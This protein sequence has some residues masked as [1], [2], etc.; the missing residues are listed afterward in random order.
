MKNYKFLKSLILIFIFFTALTLAQ[1]DYQV[2]QNFKDKQQQ[3]ENAITNADSLG[4]LEELSNDIDDLKNNYSQYKSL[5]DKSLYPEDFN[6]SINKLNNQLTLRKG[7]FTQISVL[8][9]QV[10]ELKDQFDMLN[11]RNNEL[12]SQV[13]QLEE[14]SKKDNQKIAQLERSVS[15]LKASLQKRDDLVMTMIDS[16]IPASSRVENLSSEEKNKVISEAKKVNL[17]SNILRSIHDNI[18]FIELT[19]LTPDDVEQ[20]KKQEEDFAKMWRSAGP[21]IIDI[22]SARGE[23]VNHLKEVDSAFT[24]WHYAINAEPWNSIRQE[25]SKYNIKLPSFKNGKQFTHTMT[26]Y[27]DD[28]IKNV[29]TKGKEESEQEYKYFADSVWFPKVK[30]GWFPFLIDNKMIDANQKDSVENKIS[31]W[32]DE[33]HPSKLNWLYIIIGLLVIVIAI[34]LFRRK[35]PGGVKNTGSPNDTAQK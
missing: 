1:Q 28:Q 20:M 31:R 22:Y 33:I 5:L 24:E 9:T 3:I 18:R 13:S 15:Q 19:K 35:S 34:L 23:N 2:V 7:D 21:K 14:Q 29:G 26:S 12:I 32:N 10:T 25:F 4:E 17:I 6:S 27:I 8:K 11:Q 16:L 30:S